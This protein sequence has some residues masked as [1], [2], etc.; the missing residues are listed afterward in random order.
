M[1]YGL[2]VHN[3]TMTR[4][5]GWLWLMSGIPIGTALIFLPPS[6][7]LFCF[8][9]FVLLETGHSLSPI[10]LAWTHRG[11]RRQLIYT[12][13][14]KF[15]MLPGLVFL[16]ALSIG[17]A[18]QSGLTSYRLDVPGQL[19]RITDLTNPL[20][21]LAWFYSA[22]NIYH[23]GMQ[24]FGVLR[25]MGS[26]R[27]RLVDMGL[28]LTVA[29][30]TMGVVSHLVHD[31]WVFFLLTGM[32]SV[33]HW[34]VDIGL[35]SRVTRNGWVFIA[36]VISAGMIGFAWMVPTP[37]G[38]LVRMIPVIICAR[39]GLGFVHFLYSRWVW[40]LSDP[41]VR[42]TIGRDLLPRSDELR[43]IRVTV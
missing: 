39:L 1:Q 19:G 26:K 4:F 43:T 28:C 24:N 33:N 30:V 22:C 9:L 2:P 16:A 12:Q 14:G 34:V 13:P 32:V 10:V 23:F 7:R 29:F 37:N 6:A 5:V 11:F 3:G 38:M 18:T 31:P 8:A 20:P 35:S 15:L 21:L 40:K 17:V 27:H 25:L 42:A 36:G 41:L